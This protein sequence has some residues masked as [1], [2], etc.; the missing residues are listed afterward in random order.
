[1]CVDER[2]G[3][4]ASRR[5]TAVGASGW[6]HFTFPLSEHEVMSLGE[7]PLQLLRVAEFQQFGWQHGVLRPMF[8]GKDYFF[9]K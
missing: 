4:N 6:S 5:E 3:K 2:I 9:Y 7:S 1:M 8:V